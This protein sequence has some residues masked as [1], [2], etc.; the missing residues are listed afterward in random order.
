MTYTI[1]VDA[2]SG[3]LGPQTATAAIKDV[4]AANS[5]VQI[6]AVGDRPQLE[7]L[8]ADQERVTFEHA[9]EVIS[10]D[11]DPLK[12]LRRRQSSMF[13]TIALVAS[14]QAGAAL[15]A[16]NTGALMGMSRI[17]LKMLEG[18]RHPAIASF[19]PCRQ[20]TSSFCMLDLGANI[21]RST[22]MLV[23]F[24]YLGNALVCA[25][26][27]IKRP[28]IALLNIG[29]EN[30]KGGKELLEA[31]ACLSKIDLNF[32]G[33]IEANAL[34]EGGADV[35]VCDGF[36]GNVFLKAMEGLSAMFKGM[37]Q[38]AFYSNILT[39]AIGVV[40]AP[41]LNDLRTIMDVRRYNGAAFLGLNGL[42]VKSHGS[43][44][45][46]GFGAALEFT[47]KQSRRN[48][49]ELIRSSAKLA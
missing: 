1:A 17:Q 22:E 20:C 12:A 32:V 48:L 30:V 18:F 23:D 5:D 41:V 43:A 49:I 9:D 16:G 3:D 13:R 35:V 40:S 27:E 47:L 10:M 8:L 21:G 46:V 37:L 44:D 15:S 11:D 4:L 24:A 38:E 31:Y 19:V 34:F 6:I 25:V 39:R 28:R 36:A 26:T 2:M 42:V 29:K 33:N 14:Q 7:K 45:Q